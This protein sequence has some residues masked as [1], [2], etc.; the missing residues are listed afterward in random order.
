MSELTAP[1]V[2]DTRSRA[3]GTPVSATQLLVAGFV[4]VV[5]FL[6]LYPLLMLLLGSF[7]PAAN[8]PAGTW[9]SLDG[10]R[11]AL[12]DASARN[13]VVT[14]LWLSLV[15]AALAVVL[16]IF[17]AWAITRTNVPGRRFF[18]YV[19]LISFFIPLLPQLL[20]WTLLLSP[21][22]GTINVW[23]RG[24]LGIES[25]NGPFNIYS[26][27]GIIFVSVLAWSGF[28]YLFISP[29]FDA[30]DA[31]LEEAARMSGANSLRTLM[32]VS[33]PLLL[34]AILGA[35]GLA[36]IRMVES[37]ETE[38]L[39]GTPAQIYV[40]T[41]QVY[42][43]LSLQV[44]PN[45]PPA[46]AL[47]LLLVVLTLGVIL[48]QSKLLSGR[49]FVVVTGK[50]Y[51]RNP[52]DLGPWKYVLFVALLLFDVVHLGLPLAM[53]VLGSIQQ[54]A[55][56]F[57]LESFTLNHWRLLGSAELWDSIK[58]TLIVGAVAAT[59]TI[60]VVTLS[61]YIVVRT[62]SRFRR[63]LDVLTWAPYMV[64]SFVLGVGFLWAVLRGNPFPIVLYG[65]LAVLML[66][67]LIRLLP[68]G[69]RL[70]N[71]CMV[72]LAVELEEAARMSGASWRSTFRK[73]VVPL[74]SP[75]LAMG[76]LM[77]MIIVVRDLSTVI[78]L[79]G[80]NSRLLSIAFFANWKAGTLEDA[81]VV[82]VLMTLI[83]LGL[84]AGIFVFQRLSRTGPQSLL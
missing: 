12:E 57:R 21:R 10:Y 70:M 53:L 25:I 41:T 65:S 30:V 44:T 32:R 8:A 82:G 1:S 3:F 2:F 18:H 26:Y 71:G 34:P 48:V 33:V 49:S 61:S 47:S 20:A 24:A 7:A 79:Y 73:V 74:L 37:F 54:S 77:F 36:F 38:L 80:P 17:L 35:F 13:A 27:Q 68:L 31:S 39:L 58:N 72:Q 56:R 11:T 42:S 4:V 22:S 62:R 67:F 45:Y 43:Y 78:L 29:A 59:A 64:P 50:S 51:K 6:V 14:T 69:A 28:L 84:A 76:W 83:G 75:A 55:V 81:S 60:V 66:A 16:A 63:T 15:R 9:F 23:L 40:F 46:I 19:M 52:T 5:G